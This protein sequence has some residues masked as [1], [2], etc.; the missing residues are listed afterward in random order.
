MQLKS[1]V[2]RLRAKKNTEEVKKLLAFA[3]GCLSNANDSESF[4]NIYLNISDLLVE[5]IQNS[6]KAADP[7]E[8]VLFSSFISRNCPKLSQSQILEQKN[9]A[10]FEN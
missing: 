4:A 5:E 2:F 3:L 9:A 7:A 6:Q 10:A 1:R 8:V